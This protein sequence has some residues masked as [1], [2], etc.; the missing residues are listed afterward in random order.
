VDFWAQQ[1]DAR[2]RSGWLIFLFALAVLAVVIAVNTLVLS[3]LAL[4]ESEQLMLPDGDWLA[5]HPRAVVI[6]TLL[7]LGYLAVAHLYRTSA[8]AAGGGVVARGLGGMRVQ[9]E[10]R[11]PL[12]RR[13][14]NVV[15]EM[16]I[17]S[18]VPVPSVY[19]LEQ[20]DGINAFTAGH[21]MANAA[22]AVTRGALQRLDRAQLQGVVGHEFSH[23]LNGD[24]R[25]NIRLMGLLFGLIGM[26]VVGRRVLRAGSEGSGGGTGAF[27]LLAAAGFFM[28]IGYLGVFF[29]RLIQ[30]AVSRQRELLADSAAVQF[31]RDT[32][33]LRQALLKIGRVQGSRM[34]HPGTEEIA[35]MLFAPGLT[36][37]FAT[38]PPLA[39]RIRALGSGFDTR[40][41][42]GLHLEVR[43]QPLGIVSVL[44]TDLSQLHAFAR[45]DER[46]FNLNPATVPAM[47]A[48]PGTRELDRAREL[49]ESL[50][51]D[52]L[53]QGNRAAAA[54]AALFALALTR[55]EPGRS[56]QLKML[57]GRLGSDL[58]THAE[59]QS[60]KL[61]SLRAEQRLPLLGRLVPILRQLPAG[62]RQ[63]AV[64]CLAEF[65]RSSGAGMRSFDYA[66]CTLARCWLVESL[67]PRR[68][69][70]PVRLASAVA[71]LQLLFS[72][73]AEHGHAEAT[74]ARPAFARGVARLGL[75]HAPE[76][77]PI[78]G[79]PAALDR[80]LR[81]LDGLAPADKAKVVEGLAALIVHDGEIT[82]EESELLRA[83][84]ALLH[85][86]LPP[87]AS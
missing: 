11:D 36:R 1:A 6:T 23:I 52:L 84:C 18:G 62:S 10:T 27:I 39:E 67:Q 44:K 4:I 83:I 48:R 80:A 21:T 87:L 29:G 63:T 64:D 78:S 20:E 43:P 26:A 40:E 49:R 34:R 50:P 85:C 2:R 22:I 81:C 30:A 57:A 47:V 42:E 71:E 51:R 7:V 66:L 65:A 12:E 77:L 79:W 24:M 17:A 3:I 33:G 55:D 32:D 59:A 45:P 74:A 76:Y 73:L 60:A 72:T 70:R 38:H 16:A 15:E 31:T 19:V 53:K 54:M 75:R 25:L 46:T 41:L 86:P 68:D 35:H 61:G 8:L 82:V 5:G 56:R 9:A 28:I 69:P 58:V 37:W 13:L 14:L